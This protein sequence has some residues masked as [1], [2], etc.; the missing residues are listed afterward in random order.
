MDMD[1]IEE[2]RRRKMR[3]MEQ[4]LR[5]KQLQEEKVE[6][7][8]RQVERILG[9]VLKP[10][11]MSY[12]GQLRSSSPAVANKIEEILIGLVIQRRINYKVDKVIIRA[13][14]RKVR[15]VEPTISFSRKGKRIEISEKLRG[16]D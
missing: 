7:E 13:I 10:D 16:E 5:E 14:E 12:L 15:G 6:D 8:R 3:Q 4:R 1:E 9:Q 2:I 11:A